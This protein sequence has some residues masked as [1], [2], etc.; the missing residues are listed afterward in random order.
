M[1]YTFQVALGNQIGTSLLDADHVD[2]AREMIAKAKG[3]A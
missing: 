3:W 1:S 2:Y